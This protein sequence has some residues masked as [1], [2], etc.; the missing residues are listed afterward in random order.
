MLPIGFL[1]G[2][3]TSLFTSIVQHDKGA[4][5]GPCSGELSATSFPGSDF[6]YVAMVFAK[7]PVR[8]RENYGKG[9]AG[10][11]EFKYPDALGGRK[12]SVSRGTNSGFCGMADLVESGYG[13]K[14]VEGLGRAEVR[15]N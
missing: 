11:A 10:S 13:R 1:H 14:T 7:N 3:S 5:E 12:F 6:S 15:G 2:R 4:R 8:N 9:S